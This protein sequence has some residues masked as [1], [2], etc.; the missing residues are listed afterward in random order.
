[1]FPRWMFNSLVYSLTA[2]IIAVIVSTLAGYGLAVYKFN[3]SAFL[4]GVIL[5]LAMIP[6][7]TLILPSETLDAVLEFCKLLYNVPS[8][9]I[10]SSG[11]K[12]NVE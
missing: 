3:G 8:W 4:Q 1:M 9:F 11:N 7:N 10:S 5:F 12:H 2:T 6:A